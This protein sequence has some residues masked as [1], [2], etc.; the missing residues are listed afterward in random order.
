MKLLTTET[1]KPRVACDV[2]SWGVDAAV[3]KIISIHVYDWVTARNRITDR[4]APPSLALWLP[5]LTRSTVTISG[6]LHSRTVHQKNMLRKCANFKL[7]WN[8]PK[9]PSAIR[10][11][12]E[13]TRKFAVIVAFPG[14]LLANW[15]SITCIYCRIQAIVRNGYFSPLK[16][17][18]GQLKSLATEKSQTVHW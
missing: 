9:Q 8:V 12:G 1:S 13:Y 5:W 17:F 6:F 18:F 10:G 7:H 3:A 4:C 15:V 2:I 11:A 16:R 14:N